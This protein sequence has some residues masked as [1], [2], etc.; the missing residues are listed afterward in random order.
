M[1]P[2]R[3]L[4][5]S[6]LRGVHIDDDNFSIVCGINHCDAFYSKCSSF[7]SHVYR[8]HRGE[9]SAA[10]QAEHPATELDID[11][12]S[13]QPNFEEHSGDQAQT[14]LMPSRSIQMEHAISHILG[15]DKLFQMQKTSL[16][17]LNLK[18]FMESL[19]L[20][21]TILLMKQKQRFLILFTV[22]KLVLVINFHA[23]G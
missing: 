20:P 9:L 23:M 4:W 3:E 21:Y 2:T 22:L 5:L 17:I 8:K 13:E 15:T 7:L 18:R 11:T 16:Y 14:D 1:S 6:H 10:N 12:S 19:K